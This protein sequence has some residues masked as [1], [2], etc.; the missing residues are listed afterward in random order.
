MYSQKKQ[1]LYS[2]IS[3]Q[4]NIR[5]D[6]FLHFNLTDISREFIKASIKR[7][8]V[9]VNSKT[10]SKPS[11]RLK[12]NDNV[13]IRL[14]NVKEN[15]LYPC[16]IAI[17]IIYEDSDIVVVNKPA[18]MLSHPTSSEGS[19]SLVNALLYKYKKLSDLSGPLRPGIVH[20]LDKD[21]S[22][23]IIIAKNN[24]AHIKLAEQ[25]KNREVLKKYLALVTGRIEHDEGIIRYPISRGKY[26]RK[27]MK[28]DFTRGKES[29]TYFKVLTRLH[30]FSFVLLYPK[31]GRT[32]QLRV[33]MKYYNHPVVGDAKYGKRCSFIRRQA[34]HA[35]C[36]NFRHPVRGDNMSFKAELPEDFVGLLTQLGLNNYKEFLEKIDMEVQNV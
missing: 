6:V 15:K 9:H 28:V 14:D 10:I 32:H 31:T 2:F 20:R 36:I 12:L 29:Q 13:C 18:G 16:D 4:D 21:T 8:S 17:E 35:Y 23:L 26:E 7:A 33:H 3:K 22:G 25:F 27:K 24:L 11:Y 1:K 34:L 5:L 30:L 19:D